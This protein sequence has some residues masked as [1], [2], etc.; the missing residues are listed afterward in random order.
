VPRTVRRKGPDGP[1]LGVFLKSHLVL[2]TSSTPDDSVELVPQR[3]N[4]GAKVKTLP[5]APGLR[6]LAAPTEAR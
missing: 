4:V 5:F 1:C 2:A 6:L 3:A